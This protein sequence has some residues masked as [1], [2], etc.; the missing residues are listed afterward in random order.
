M[1]SKKKKTRNL[2]AVNAHFRNSAGP[3]RD[4]S[5]EEDK[6]KC[7]EEIEDEW[8]EEED[9]DVSDIYEEITKNKNGHWEDE[10]SET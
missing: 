6:N 8:L 3:M 10:E 2:H 9:D 4:E 7:R 5:K 1:T